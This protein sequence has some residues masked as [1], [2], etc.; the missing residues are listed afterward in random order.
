MKIGILASGGDG[1]GMNK[2]LYKLCKALK[3]HK[4]VLFARGYTGLIYGET[5]DFDSSLL[6]Y[7]HYL[8]NLLHTNIQILLGFPLFAYIQ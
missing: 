6:H 1:A 8:Q 3:K 7:K 4:V 2:C 5:Y